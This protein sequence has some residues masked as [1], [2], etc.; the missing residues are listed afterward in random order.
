MKLPTEGRTFS[1]VSVSLCAF[2][3]AKIPP[4]Y[5]AVEFKTALNCHFEL[6][7]SIFLGPHKVLTPMAE[8]NGWGRAVSV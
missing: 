4:A 1:N 2:V 3:S 6:N 5:S 8:D 7:I